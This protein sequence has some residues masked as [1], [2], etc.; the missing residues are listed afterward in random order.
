MPPPSRLIQD[1]DSVHQ[2]EPDQWDLRHSFGPFLALRGSGYL[3]DASSRSRK[4]LLGFNASP[5]FG[6]AHQVGTGTLDRSSDEDRML[7]TALLE[8]AN[9][10]QS[11]LVDRLEPRRLEQL[12]QAVNQANASRDLVSRTYIT[13]SVLDQ[14]ID[15]LEQISARINSELQQLTPQFADLLAGYRAEGLQ[16]ELEF[17][18]TSQ[19]ERFHRRRFDFGIDFDVV[20]QAARFGWVLAGDQQALDLLWQQLKKLLQSTR[21]ESVETAETPLCPPPSLEQNYR[22]A[23]WML[24]SHHRPGAPAP[25][26][27][28]NQ[29]TVAYLQSSLERRSDGMELETI[30]LNPGSYP[31]YRD[32]VLSLQTDIY[33]PAR[34]T[35][36]EE[37]DA[38]FQSAHP[39]ALLLL[40]EGR[41][42]GMGLAGP[43]SQFP[44]VRGVA[45][46]PFRTDSGTLYMVDV[47]VR[48]EYRGGL[49][50]LIKQ[51]I[52]LLAQQRGF[53]AIHGRNRDRLAR[54]MWSINLSLGSFELQHLVDD[55]PD[56]GEFRDCLYYR[57]PLQWTSANMASDPTRSEREQRLVQLP[58]IIH[59]SWAG[60]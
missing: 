5:L 50:K 25:P 23:E 22:F 4:P 34:Q 8:L 43:I 41:I 19:L 35:S 14:Y 10:C 15:Q 29:R 1:E 48:E 12:A 55:Y 36:A 58:E 16:F 38:I 21:G 18:E 51:A 20:G 6:L 33:E 42:V 26:D 40:A 3:I 9:R 24:A 7:K 44:Q 11:H 13:L 28:A 45:S 57:C 17:Q 39:V 60:A 53:R 52:T 37:F 46:D 30:I 49:G 32:Q 2:V 59:G 31:V 54:G 56:E 47:T 27:V